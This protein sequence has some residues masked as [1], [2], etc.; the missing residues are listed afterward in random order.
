MLNA[1][2]IMDI[3]FAERFGMMQWRYNKGDRG[4]GAHAL[5]DFP[6]MATY[7][8]YESKQM[9]AALQYLK[10]APAI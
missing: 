6:F 1:L 9:A 10:R 8:E 5:Y 7:T 3:T 4:T 2:L